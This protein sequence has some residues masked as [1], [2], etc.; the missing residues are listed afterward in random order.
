MTELTR[1]EVEIILK[2]DGDLRGVDLSGLDLAGMNFSQARL[3]GVSFAYCNLE[4]AIF[5]RGDTT[6][7]ERHVLWNVDFRGANL[8]HAN[9]CRCT[10]WFCKFHGAR[11]DGANLQGIRGTTPIKMISKSKKSPPPR[12]KSK[13][14]PTPP[15]PGE[16]I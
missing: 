16:E 2:A 13:R 10:L 7:S 15:P 11:L 5:S 6:F 1:G 12:P 3:R 8:E 14:F 4:R 9:F